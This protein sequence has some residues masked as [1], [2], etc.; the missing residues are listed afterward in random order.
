LPLGEFVD[1]AHEVSLWPAQQQDLAVADDH[2]P[3]DQLVYSVAAGFFG[4]LGE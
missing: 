1:P 3:D 2:G 4:E